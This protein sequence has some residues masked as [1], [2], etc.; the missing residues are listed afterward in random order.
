MVGG[1]LEMFFR[2]ASGSDTSRVVLDIT[3]E[4]MVASNFPFPKQLFPV[5]CAQTDK[6]KQ[7]NLQISMVVL[8]LAVSVDSD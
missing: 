1:S 6:L 2:S 4:S 7:N 8:Q 5:D 3:R